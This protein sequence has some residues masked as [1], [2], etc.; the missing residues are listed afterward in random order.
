MPNTHFVRFGCHRCFDFHRKS[1]WRE[2]HGADAPSRYPGRSLRDFCLC[3]CRVVSCLQVHN[4][5]P[6]ICDAKKSCQN[7]A[8][9][10]VLQRNAPFLILDAKKFIE[11]L[12]TCPPLY[13]K[14]KFLCPLD[15]LCD[16]NVT[17]Y[18]YLRGTCVL[19]EMR[20]PPFKHVG[21]KYSIDQC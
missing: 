20:S 1:R 13:L 3:L 17:C 5:C 7:P 2:W 11:N 19:N 12:A 9:C 6:S 15:T 14:G 16:C 18:S 10:L 4:F 8:S 21:M